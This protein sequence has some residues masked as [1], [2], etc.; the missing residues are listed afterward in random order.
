MDEE[1]TKVEET[2][3]TTEVKID[4]DYSYCETVTY[5]DHYDEYYTYVG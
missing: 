2:E 1:E 3:Q 4:I 5:V